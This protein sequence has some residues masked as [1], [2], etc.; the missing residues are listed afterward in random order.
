MVYSRY[1]LDI[2]LNNRAMKTALS[3]KG[4]EFKDDNGCSSNIKYD[5]FKIHRLDVPC[6]LCLKGGV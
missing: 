6:R 2:E 4:K 1:V 3:L 5:S